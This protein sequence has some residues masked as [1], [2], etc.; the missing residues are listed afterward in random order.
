MRL[1]QGL[2]FPEW[3]MSLGGLAK[4]ATVVAQSTSHAVNKRLA[5][6]PGSWAIDVIARHRNFETP[7]CDHTALCAKRAGL[8]KS[9]DG[10]ARFVRVGRAMSL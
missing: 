10:E 4:R 6:G 9:D 3:L 1:A 8:T 2:D 5:P 7:A